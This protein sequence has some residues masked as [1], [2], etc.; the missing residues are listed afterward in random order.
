MELGILT[1]AFAIAT[2]VVIQPRRAL[3]IL[4]FGQRAVRALPEERV[5]V[6]RVFAA[7]MAVGVLVLVAGWAISGMA[8]L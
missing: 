5:R 8:P 7:I 6:V 1:V 3:L 2:W 4:F